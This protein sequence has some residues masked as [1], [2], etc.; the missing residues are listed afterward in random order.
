MP[1][2]CTACEHVEETTETVCPK[3]GA[4]MR[5]SLL[6]GLEFE[7]DH[8][9]VTR[10]KDGETSSLASRI[11]QVVLGTVAVNA[12]AVGLAFLAVVGIAL[13]PH[14]PETLSKDQP[15]IFHSIALGILILAPVI[16]V[17][18]QLRD[19]YMAQFIGAAIGFLGTTIIAITRV[20]VGIPIAFYEWLAIPTST[21]LCFLVGLQRTGTPAVA[22]VFEF[23]P[24]NSWDKKSRPSE[25]EL[26]PASSKPL[27]QLLLGVLV[28]LVCWNGLGAVL[29]MLL[30][31]L[32]RNPTLL[33]TSLARVEYPLQIVAC[34]AA[35]MVAGAS[36]RAGFAQGLFAGILLVIMRQ[37]FDPSEGIEE[38]IIQLVLIIAATSIGGVYGRKIFRPY[39]IFGN[40]ISNKRKSTPQ[41]TAAAR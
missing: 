24:I 28:G 20:Y 19:V 18:L 23:K 12:T 7:D 34:F 13:S 5:M 15:F 1:M 8:S 9:G 25:K 35:G 32:V 3:C 36:T 14:S 26:T 37:M 6:A 38:L 21:A 31:P 10:I 22:E 16:V 17:F 29:A 11:Q 33:Q 41:E 39:R 30:R 40:A 2:L 4:P 27:N